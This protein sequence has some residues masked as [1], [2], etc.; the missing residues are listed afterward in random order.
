MASNYS[1]GSDG[2][3]VEPV[4]SWVADKHRFLRHYVGIAASTRR[5]FL[6][7]PDSNAGAAYIDLYCGPGRCLITETGEEVAGS[8]LAA[9]AE[10]F[11]R[12]APF[13]E[14][15][16]ADMDPLNVET[17]AARLRRYLESQDCSSP[18]FQ[19]AGAAADVATELLS[20]LTPNG[21]HLFFMDPYAM[22][23]L[24]FHLIRQ[25]ASLHRP[26]LLVHFSTFDFQRNLPKAIRDADG[27]HGRSF[28]RF[29]PGWRSSVDLLTTDPARQRSQY[30][31]HWLRLL[32]GIGFKNIEPSVDFQLITG[33]NNQRLYWLVLMSKSPLAR[34]FWKRISRRAQG[35]LF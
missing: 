21:L 25:I 19:Y 22:D 28:E 9:A 14:F 35:E 34:D 20:R 26:D 15:H 3:R 16:L 30:I 27:V 12:G 31:E 33:D 29:A 17:A 8:P 18:V 32:G 2:M 13:S 10:A 7:P 11:A 6:P 24:P 5:K 4:H 1:D 23:P